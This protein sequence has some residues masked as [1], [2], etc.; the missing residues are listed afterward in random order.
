MAPP[1]KNGNQEASAEDVVDGAHPCDKGAERST[2]GREPRPANANAQEPDCQGEV[3]QEHRAC[4]DDHTLSECR[5][6]A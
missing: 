1:D 6:L 2:A 5:M 3:D 4:D